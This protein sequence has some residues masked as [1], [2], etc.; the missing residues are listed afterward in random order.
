MQDLEEIAK[1]ISALQAKIAVLQ[2][3]IDMVKIMG[4]IMENNNG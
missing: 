3:E 4:K 1:R 2:A